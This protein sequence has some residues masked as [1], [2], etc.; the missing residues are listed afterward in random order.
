[1]SSRLL[2]FFLVIS[3]WRTLFFSVIEIGWRLRSS[4]FSRRSAMAV[5]DSMPL[6]TVP[7]AA[8][9]LK[10]NLGTAGSYLVLRGRRCCG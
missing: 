5:D 7:S 8:A 1:M 3:N 4:R 9:A 6:T 10:R 2:T